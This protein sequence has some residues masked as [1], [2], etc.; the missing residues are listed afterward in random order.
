MV[1]VHG[2]ED[3]TLGFQG[4]RGRP[5]VP[6]GLAKWRRADACSD[7]MTEDR[8][9]EVTHVMWAECA[10]GTAIELYTIDHGKHEWPGAVPKRGNDPVSHAL[11]ATTTIWAFF[12]GHPR[13]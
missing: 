11:D 6:D 2:L 9:G 5:A 10:P 7:D 1:H 3:E 12:V 13:A 8:E 4:G